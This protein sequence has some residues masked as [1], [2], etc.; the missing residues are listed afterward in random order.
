MQVCVQTATMPVIIH[1]IVMMC[2]AHE[3]KTVVVV[4]KFNKKLYN[5][6]EN[7]IMCTLVLFFF[8]FV[9]SFAY[10]IRACHVCTL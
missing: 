10:H 6:T 1:N 9:Y 8:F 5:I 3:C 7:R 2:N 4:Y